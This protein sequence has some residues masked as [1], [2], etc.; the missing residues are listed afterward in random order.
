MKITQKQG[1]IYLGHQYDHLPPFDLLAIQRN[2]WRWFLDEGLA[3]SLANISP[4]EDQTGNRW[5]LTIGDYFI[6]EP[7][8]SPQEA[9]QRSASYVSSVEVEVTL[10][11]KKTDRTWQKRIFLFDLPQMTQNATFIINGVERAIITQ[12]TRAP[13]VY[14]TSEIDKRTGNT[15]YEAEVRPL[16]GSW[17]KLATN[18]NGT[19]SVRIDRRRQFPVTILLKALEE[20][21]N[22][23]IIEKYGKGIISTLEVDNTGTREEALLAIYQ[24]MRPGEPAVLENARGFFYN[25]FFNPRRYNLSEVGRFKINKKLGLKIKNEKGNFI[26]QKEDFFAVLSYLI[27]VQNGEGK[28]DDI[29]HLSNRYLRSVGQLIAQVPFRIGLSRFERM[30]RNRMVLLSKNQNV[31]LSSLINTQPIIAAINEFFRTNRLSA[32]LDQTNPLS[33]LDNLRRLSVMGPGGLTRER[34]PFSIR[35]VSSSQYGRIC[36]V[37]SPE[38]QNIGLVTYLALY[39]R[40]NKYGFLESPYRKVKKVKKNGKIKMKITDEIV[41]LPADDE[42]NYYITANDINVKNSYI[43]DQ[44]VQARYQG[45][46]LDVAVEQVQLIDISPRQIVG[47]SAS[48]IPFL[49]NDEPSRALMGS[50]MECQAVPLIDSESPVI[51]TGMERV[52]PEAMEW[53][54]RAR[55]DGKVIFVDG[56]KVVIKLKRRSDIKKEDLKNEHIKIE[57]GNETYKIV[58]FKRTSPYGTCYSQRAIV[59]VGEEVTKGDLLIDGPSCQ[60]GELALGKNLHIAYC[61]FEGLGYEDA[62]A[63]SDCLLHND[64]FTSITINKYEAE[65][66]D[67]K[68]GPEELTSDIPSASESELAKLGNDGIV[69]VGSHVNAGDILVG[70]IAPKGET[71][72][73]AEERLLRAVFGEKARDVRDT[74]LRL[75]HGVEGIVISVNVLGR[76]KENEFSPGINKKV[77]VQVAQ[78]RKIKIGDKLSGRHGNKGIIA[79]IVPQADMPYL[80]DGTPIDIVISP[81]SVLSRMN[82]GQLLET[83]IGWAATKLGYKVALP[84]FEEFD[85]EFLREEF[86]KAGLPADYKARLYDGK[87]GQAFEQRV[88]VGTA[89]IL[90]LVHMVEDKIHARSIG[91]YSLVTQQPLGGR[92]QMGGQRFGEMEVWALE[93]HRAA[94]TLQEMLTIKSDD[95]VGRGKAFEAIVKGLTIPAS[96]LPESFKVLVSELKGLGLSIIPKGVIED[97]EV[98]EGGEKND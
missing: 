82:L 51:G 41:Y 46:F 30:I 32:I 52:I 1:R 55:H 88:V 78:M 87:T 97:Y 34:A 5:S 84:V 18:N 64:S 23:K 37:R 12:I 83:H 31:N 62:I 71:E 20:T 54:V 94:Y 60:K 50:H 69:L 3:S 89:Y 81:L 93:A 59:N 25:A 57:N 98:D 39:T 65:V 44:L 40:V 8:C 16:N 2:S 9:M 33:E 21:S 91:P 11:N 77:T 17:L 26:L 47:A 28:L 13:G 79:K 95:V 67:T 49:D 61:S 66:S 90:K 15:L 92:A 96:Q 80:A 70:K 73:N 63:I 74:S 68:L 22:K 36:P 72:L 19:I 43:T 4:I 29:D 10:R 38:G 6:S 76:E 48:L 85:E 42:E 24:K 27:K 58:K 56:T 53:V 75:P 14:F 7:G 45:K 35:D 86:K